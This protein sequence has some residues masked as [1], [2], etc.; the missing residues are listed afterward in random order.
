MAVKSARPQPAT[1]DGGLAVARTQLS[2]RR[3]AL[4][5]IAAAFLAA[6]YS[7]EHAH[8]APSLLSYGAALMLLVWFV[9][10][11]FAAPQPSADQLTLA[12]GVAMIGVATTTAIL[13]G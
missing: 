9:A 8:V 4:A 7:I 2:W 10:R 6:R 1:D 5:V 11:E 12:M 3:S 13:L